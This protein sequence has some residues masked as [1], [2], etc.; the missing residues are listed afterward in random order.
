MTMTRAIKIK[1]CH[2]VAGMSPYCLLVFTHTR[3]HSVCQYCKSVL[4]D[5]HIFFLQSSLKFQNVS[6][7]ILFA[8]SPTLLTP[9]VLG[10]WHI[11]M[12]PSNSSLLIIVLPENPN[13]LMPHEVLCYHAR[14][15]D[16]LCVALQRGPRVELGVSHGILALLWNPQW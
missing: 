11:L 4:G 12:Q 10:G 15:I 8:N 9:K 13:L 16:F 3:T 7:V 1:G 14:N 5:S 2:S 6:D